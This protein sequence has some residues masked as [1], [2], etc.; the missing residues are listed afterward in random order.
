MQGLKKGKFY[1]T[2]FHFYFLMTSI[3]YL[4]LDEI[5]YHKILL[6][7]N[8]L[9]YHNFEIFCANVCLIFQQ[10]KYYVFYKSVGLNLSRPRKSVCT[11][12]LKLMQLVKRMYPPNML[13]ASVLPSTVTSLVEQKKASLVVISNDN[14]LR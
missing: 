6:M 10:L 5:S 1:G 4:R 2:L 12:E 7:E 13:F 14:I 9:N 8:L 11:R 3:C